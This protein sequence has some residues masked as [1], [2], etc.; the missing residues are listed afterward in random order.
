VKAVESKTMG[1]DTYQTPDNVAVGDAVL[2][3]S[4]AEVTAL[5]LSDGDYIL[6]ED[7]SADLQ[8]NR[9]K[10]STSTVVTLE[11]ASTVALTASDSDLVTKLFQVEAM[12]L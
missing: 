12:I 10:S 11:K 3:F 4:S 9:R 5:N 8:V 7:L 6:I 2:T 1:S